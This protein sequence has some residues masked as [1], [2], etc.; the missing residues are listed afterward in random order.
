MYGES[1]IKIKIK[2]L[3]NNCKV[4]ENYS[5]V[6]CKKKYIYIIT[7]GKGG[8]FCVNKNCKI[9]HKGV[10]FK[11][12]SFQPPKF[13]SLFFIF[14]SDFSSATISFEIFT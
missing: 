7:S 11:L 5:S 14:Y 2:D 8:R 4:V 3:A 13:F 6:I 10:I 9:P 12:A 1:F